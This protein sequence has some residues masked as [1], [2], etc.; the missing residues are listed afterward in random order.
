[1]DFEK[2][3][4]TVTMHAHDNNASV[5]KY[6]RDCQKQMTSA[7]DTWHATKGLARDVK[8]LCVGPACKEGH[9][10]FAD[11]S[12]KAA[13]IKTQD[14]LKLETSLLNICEH[15]KGNHAMCRSTSRCKTVANYIPTKT[16]INNKKA[17][18]AL[19]AFVTSTNIYKQAESYRFCA[20]THYVESYNNA[21]L[22][23]HD[24]HIC[25]D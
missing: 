15:Y 17:E 20:D 6:I 8:K 13:S 19:K 21:R 5:S 12:D 9:T 7:K 1:M 14:K 4:I 18:D 10:W 24:K 23:Y 22:Q 16:V 3:N 25:F 2:D 11:L